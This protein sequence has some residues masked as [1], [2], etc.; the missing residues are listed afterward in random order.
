MPYTAKNRLF[1]IFLNS[2]YSKKMIKAKDF[3]FFVLELD[4]WIGNLMIF[5][6]IFQPSNLE[7]YEF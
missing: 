3:I 1:F 5:W 6:V 4:S 7:L 2:F